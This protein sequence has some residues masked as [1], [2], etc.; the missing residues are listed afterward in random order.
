MDTTGKSTQRIAAYI[1]DQLKEDQLSDQM[2]MKEYED[3]FTGI[4]VFE[5]AFTVHA[6]RCGS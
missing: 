6:L 2:I 1:R 5:D 3:P 4:K